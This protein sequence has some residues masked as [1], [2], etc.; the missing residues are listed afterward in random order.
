M[1]SAKWR[2]R[3][4][5]NSWPVPRAV[6]STT[7]RRARRSSCTAEADDF[8]RAP[9]GPRHVECFNNP[10][11]LDSSVMRC[12]QACEMRWENRFVLR[13]GRHVFYWVGRFLGHC[14]ILSIYQE[15]DAIPALLIFPIGGNF[16]P[17]VVTPALSPSRAFFATDATSKT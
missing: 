16:Q 10:A 3:D 1:A 6:P 9:A 7:A 17:S 5:K 12:F 13:R 8:S 15:S 2:T 11:E 4:W 14:H